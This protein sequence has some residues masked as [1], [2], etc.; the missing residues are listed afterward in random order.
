MT[1]RRAR[2]YPTP[3][4]AAE[5]L[6]AERCDHGEII[7]RCALCRVAAEAAADQD[8]TTPTD[9]RSQSAAVVVDDE[10]QDPRNIPWWD[11]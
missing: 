7:G 3:T 2:H 11:R 4:P 1:V 8:V 5:L 6:A 10:D 9:T